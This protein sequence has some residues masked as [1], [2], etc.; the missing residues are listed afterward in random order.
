[1]AMYHTT[2]AGHE[3]FS[4]KMMFATQYVLQNGLLTHPLQRHVNAYSIV[5]PDVVGSKCS[6]LE[7]L[8]NW[9]SSIRILSKICKENRIS[10]L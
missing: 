2:V 9:F 1:M 10:N 3:I 5:V 4:E 7:S 6:F 8:S